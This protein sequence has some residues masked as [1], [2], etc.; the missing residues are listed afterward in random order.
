MTVWTLKLVASSNGRGYISSASSTAINHLRFCTL[1]SPDVRSTAEE[2]HTHKHPSAPDS[3]T[4][5]RRWRNTVL[6]IETSE[7]SPPISLNSPDP[8]M[9][10]GPSMPWE[11]RN[12]SQLNEPGPSSHSASPSW[13]SSSH[14]SPAPSES[15]SSGFSNSRP[16]SQSHS[17]SRLPTRQSINVD[18][19]LH[20]PKEKQTSFENRIARLTASAG[21]PLSWVDKYRVD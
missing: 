11:L 19:I 5:Q 1:V 12:M 8:P 6:H 13:P 4:S 18:H 17:Y 14:H 2:Y 15:G 20:W 21:F 10:A 3:P 7:M 16:P 9:V